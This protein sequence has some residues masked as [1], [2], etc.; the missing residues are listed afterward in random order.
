M[1]DERTLSRLP[2]L[3]D[4]DITG[5]LEVPVSIDVAGVRATRKMTLDQ[6]ETYL[7]GT[8]LDPGATPSVS[9]IDIH[10][11]PLTT[12]AWNDRLLLS[13][14]SASG[15]PNRAA[16][17]ERVVYAALKQ[18]LTAGAG[19]LL[20]PVDSTRRITVAS[21]VIGA[22]IEIGTADVSLPQV[23]RL[24][25]TGIT[26]PSVTTADLYLIR[27][28]YS[29][30]ILWHPVDGSRF[31][32]LAESSYGD[33]VSPSSAGELPVITAAAADAPV[34]I[35]RDSSLDVAASDI[36]AS[37]LSAVGGV[38]MDDDHVWIAGV[39]TETVSASSI[40]YV[41]CFDASDGSRVTSRDFEF[42]TGA[43]SGSSNTFLGLT[44]IASNGSHVWVTGLQ[45][46]TPTSLVAWTT[47]GVRASDRDISLG[48]VQPGLDTTFGGIATDDTNV[49]VL[50]GTAVVQVR[51]YRLSDGASIS[52]QGLAGR[53]FRWTGIATDGTR[54]WGATLGD[55]ISATTIA[56]GE[57]DAAYSFTIAEPTGV[58]RG[59]TH[60]D[61]RIRVLL[62]HDDGSAS[63]RGYRLSGFHRSR[64]YVGRGAGNEVLVG[65]DSALFDSIPIR[66]RKLQ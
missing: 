38:A 46:G 54:V 2:V 8:G 42:G 61:G 29:G 56:D 58:L 39:N 22:S 15:S 10:A 16:T 50:T 1:A 17:V 32:A 63:V 40:H 57:S 33:A 13:D 31:A 55:Y 44:G 60:R 6:L 30:G 62:Q 23:S 4:T 49:Y 36:T 59:I 5:D 35:I 43:L 65:A 48:S 21:T 37:G 14:E 53:Q 26:I 9:T 18:V 64:L 12:P 20:P 27:P 3:L 34:D 66:V 7:R 25:G 51:V 52:A 45:T 11:T 19:I 24:Y 41:R 28:E 47:A